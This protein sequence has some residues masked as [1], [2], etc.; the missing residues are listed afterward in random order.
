M[1]STSSDAVGFLHAFPSMSLERLQPLKEKMNATSIDATAAKRLQRTRMLHT[2]ILA[3]VPAVKLEDLKKMSIEWVHG[4]LEAT[5]PLETALVDD[6]CADQSAL[7]A[8]LWC[9]DGAHEIARGLVALVEGEARQAAHQQE[10]SA[11]PEDAVEAEPRPT[12][13]AAM[14]ADPPTCTAASAQATCAAPSAMEAPVE[15]PS[16][17][18]R[19]TQSEVV[20]VLQKALASGASLSEVAPAPAL[21]AQT[22]GNDVWEALCWRRG[23][24][25]YYMAS[26]AIKQQLGRAPG[27]PD[28]TP[29]LTAEATSTGSSGLVLSP[30]LLSDGRAAASVV[31]LLAEAHTALNLLLDAR[32]EPHAP[33]DGQGPPKN[34]T[35]THYGVWSTTHLLA[36]AF[37]GEICCAYL[38]RRQPH[39]SPAR[40]ASPHPRRQ[41]TPASPVRVRTL[42]PALA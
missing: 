6:D 11:T 40:V 25:R 21:Q 15:A 24:L 4:M 3:K 30:A 18:A 27:G 42:S 28:D 7:Q 33:P 38:G 14:A 39:C 29:R 5:F 17:A 10:V 19:P 22:L 35:A 36:L 37:D 1:G 2:V 16:S 23:A 26:T 9:L 20:E 34:V 41:P 12:N 31:P 8:I 32:Q 13:E